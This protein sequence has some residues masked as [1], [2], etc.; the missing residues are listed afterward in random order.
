MEATKIG[1]LIDECRKVGAEFKNLQDLF[2]QLRTVQ[3][4]K[5]YNAFEKQFRDASARLKKARSYSI[6]PHGCI[7]ERAQQKVESGDYDCDEDQTA[8]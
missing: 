6:T 3:A 2:R 8:S 7:F 5:S 4:L 1:A